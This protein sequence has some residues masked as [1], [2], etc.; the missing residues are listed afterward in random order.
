MLQVHSLIFFSECSIKDIIKGDCSKNNDDV[1]SRVQLVG[2][3]LDGSHTNCRL[4]HLP[5]GGGLMREK[6]GSSA[7]DVLW[8]FA[9]RSSR[10]VLVNY[11]ISVWRLKEFRND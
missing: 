3:D 1:R 4:V 9:L 5:Q 10:R 11:R 8:L 6:E 7:E 2:S